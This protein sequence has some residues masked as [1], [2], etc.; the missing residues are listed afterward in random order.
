MSGIVN[1]T[2]AVSGVIGTTSAPAIGTGTDGYLLTATG[3][4]VN[5]A[6]ETAPAGGLTTA[7]IWRLTSNVS[8]TGFLTSG[9][10]ESDAPAGF[11]VLGSSMTESS[12]I[13]T[14]PS[15]G[16]WQITGHGY[17]QGEN[18]T[19]AYLGFA[20]YATTDNST[21]SQGAIKYSSM[22]SDSNCHAG[23]SC[24]FIFDV[25]NVSTHKCK[26]YAQQESSVNNNGSTGVNYTHVIYSRLG[27]T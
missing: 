5:P 16:Y 27:D 12:G 9:W 4:G 7:S 18:V 21:F 1:S 6:W 11:G 19:V 3:A 10:E 14:F 20:I 17:F 15:T 13:F 2:G 26:F 24:D 22:T 23:V 25:T 8:G